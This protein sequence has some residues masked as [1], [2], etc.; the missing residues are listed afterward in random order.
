MNA[1]SDSPEMSSGSLAAKRVFQAYS[2]EKDKEEPKTK[3]Q[4]CNVLKLFYVE[5]RKADGNAYC[6]NS[7]TSL[8]FG[9]CRHYKAVVSC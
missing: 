3:A 4:I 6:K 9:L 2:H 7:L 1:R 5:A 8:R